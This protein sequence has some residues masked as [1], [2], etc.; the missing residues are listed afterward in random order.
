MVAEA[1]RLA[2]V[3]GLTLEPAETTGSYKGVTKDKTKQ[4]KPYKAQIRQG[5]MLKTLG[6]FATAEEAALA[7]ARA[8]K[9]KKSAAGKPFESPEALMVAE[10]VRLASVEGLTQEP[11][12]TT[13]GYKGVQYHKNL[14]SKPYQAQI[15]QGGKTTSLGFFAKAEEAAL[16]FA[17]ADREKKIAA[18][19]P[20]DPEVLKAAAVQLAN[21]EGLKLE[22]ADTTG[23][24]KGVTK[25]KRL[26]SKPYQAK[27]RRDGKEKYLGTFATAEE[28]ALAF[29]RADNEWITVSAARSLAAMVGDA[30]MEAR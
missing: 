20:P 26:W 28:A 30:A 13:S 25:D 8:D 6:C 15:S 2:S 17:R 9:E 1:V 3:E 4:S 18:G 11:A 14:K 12:E 22:P 23:G 29:A 7:F 19:K 24:Y 10:A 5:G 21:E 16:A 27:I